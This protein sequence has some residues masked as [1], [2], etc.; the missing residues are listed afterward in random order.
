MRIAVLINFSSVYFHSIQNRRGT[1]RNWVSLRP[2][3]HRGMTARR[4]RS[5]AA[6]RAALLA[7]GHQR[8]LD[9]RGRAGRAGAGGA[10]TARPGGGPYPPGPAQAQRGGLDPSAVARSP[11][12]A[13]AHPGADAD[14]I[15][16]RLTSTR[17]SRVAPRT[18]EAL[19]GRSLCAATRLRDHL[20]ADEP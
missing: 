18:D 15:L 14:G 4:G 10:G 13:L 6:G 9:A 20:F 8:G 1:S 11:D 12:A 16:R 17:G 19:A 7:A 5:G 2:D 3:S